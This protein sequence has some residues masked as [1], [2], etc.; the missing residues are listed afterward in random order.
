MKKILVVFISIV[1]I[2]LSLD[3]VACVYYCHE[4]T[5]FFK[6]QN[7]SKTDSAVVFFGD[8]LPKLNGLGSETIQRLEHVS[9]LY[10]NGA[11]GNIICAGGNGLRKKYGVYGSRMMRNYLIKTGVSDENIFYDT[12]SYDSYSNWEEARKIIQRHNWGKVGLVSS[13]LHLY[14]LSNI[15]RDDSLV[16]SYSPYQNRCMNSLRDFFTMREWIH[17]EWVAVI[18]LK[19]IPEPLYRFLVSFIRIKIKLLPQTEK[20]ASS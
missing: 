6:E 12:I 19:I 4:V 8:F 13:A 2:L 16:L 11:T 1:L 14:R 7:N 17:H 15:I 5:T 3:Y 10:K 9:E 20:P 18:A